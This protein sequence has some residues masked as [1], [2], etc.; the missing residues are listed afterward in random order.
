MKRLFLFVLLTVG[1]VLTIAAQESLAGKR[2]GILGD[3]YV[4]NHREPIE[5][6]WHYKFAKR[7]GMQYFNYGRNGNCVSIDLKQ[8]GRAMV[9]RYQEMDD[10]LDYVVVIAGHNDAARLDSIGADLFR[11]KLTELCDG[12]IERYPR[13]QLFFFTPWMR[14]DHDVNAHNFEVVVDC[15]LQVCASRSIPVFDAYHHGNIYA[16]SDHFR[17]LFFQNGRRDKAHLNAKGHD[18]FLPI[19]EHFIMQYISLDK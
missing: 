5:N 2:I 11:E 8:W 12:L 10:S 4:R 1:S 18:R 3:S 9:N 16:Q 17:D 13:A 19:A 7:H 6:T 15:I 14:A